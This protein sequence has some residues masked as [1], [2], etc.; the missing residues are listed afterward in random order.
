MSGF[1][2]LD[3]RKSRTALCS[4]MTLGSSPIL[5]RAAADGGGT[6]L[7]STDRM[8]NEKAERDAAAKAARRAEEASIVAGLRAALQPDEQLLGFARA[9]IAGGIKGRLNIGPEAFFAPFVNI[10]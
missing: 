10:G 2:K 5:E 9:R 1:T 8:A 4:N 6:M 3:T 7:N